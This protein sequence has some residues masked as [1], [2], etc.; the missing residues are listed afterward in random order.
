MWAE[1][2]VYAFPEFLIS[3]GTKQPRGVWQ[4]INRPLKMTV[5]MKSIKL[6]FALLIG[7]S[8]LSASTQRATA[9]VIVTLQDNGFGGTR[10]TI[11]GSFDV[12]ASPLSTGTSDNSNRFFLNGTALV[13]RNV[14]PGADSRRINFAASDN[15]T[16]IFTGAAFG[17]IPG[18]LS[19]GF[20]GTHL[21]ISENSGRII[22]YGNHP[23]DRSLNESFDYTTLSFS[24]FNTGTW[25]W[26]T[27]GGA[28]NDGMQLN[29]LSSTAAV[30]EP[31]SFA[32]LGLGSVAFAGYRRRKLKQVA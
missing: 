12:S 19:S 15:S 5:S 21:E 22:V 4:K 31:S 1:A 14:V 2:C 16:P 6:Q 18:Q 25:N 13:W 17:N 8:I 10:G 9:D 26:G 27:F 30:P 28:P 23:Y 32:I 20:L 24:D 11:T 7:V 29:I 3:T